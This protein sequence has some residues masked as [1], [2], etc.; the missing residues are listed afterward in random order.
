MYKGGGFE[1]ARD[2]GAVV[3]ARLGIYAGRRGALGYMCF[4]ARGAEM[5]TRRARAHDAG[6]ASG[7]FSG[8]FSGIRHIAAAPAR[9]AIAELT[10]TASFGTGAAV[11]GIATFR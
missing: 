11:A 1:G 2:V 10:S 6:A 8:M 7:L 9:L 5:S 4:W 3:G